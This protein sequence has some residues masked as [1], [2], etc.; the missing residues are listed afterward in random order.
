MDSTTYLKQSARTASTQFHDEIIDAAMLEH[1]L[2]QAIATGS[3]VDSVKK[4][5]FYGKALP[6]QSPLRHHEGGPAPLKPD[7]IHPDILHAALG[8][9]TEAA[10]LLEAVLQAMRGDAFDEV[11]AFE[12]LGD[13][14]WYLA[15]LYRALGKTPEQAMEVNIQKLKK[16][17]PKQFESTDAIRRDTAAERDILESGHQRTRT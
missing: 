5:L 10:E 6:E 17:Y 1:T 9:Y 12:E 7:A 2:Q 3:L 13:T 11:N 15:M 4:S 16:R 8:V 14:E